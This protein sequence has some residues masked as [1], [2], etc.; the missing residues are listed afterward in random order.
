MCHCVSQFHY[1]SR[2]EYVSQASYSSL[3][4]RLDQWMGTVL[5][6]WTDGE[7]QLEEWTTADLQEVLQKVIA[8]TA[9]L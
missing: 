9:P 6:M 3:F 5:S 8:A 7:Q 1:L 2:S 4:A